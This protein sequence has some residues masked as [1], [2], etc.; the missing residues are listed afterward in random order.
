M[1]LTGRLRRRA[2]EYRHSLSFRFSRRRGTSSGKRSPEL[3]VSL[4]TIPERIRAVGLCLDSILGQ[5]LKPDRIML[6]LSEGNGLSRQDVLTG[7]HS[8]RFRRLIERGVEVRWC[9]DIRSYRKIIPT[10]REHPEALIVTADDDIMYPRHWLRTLFTAYKNEPRYIHCHL[11]HQIRHDESGRPLPYRQWLMGSPGSLGPSLDL[12]P[13]G[14][15]GALYAPGHLHE[16]VLNEEAFLS[17]C[18]T[19]DD[20]WLKAM[21][22]LKGVACKKVSMDTMPLPAIRI[23]RNRALF[24]ENVAGGGNDRQITAVMN[25]YGVFWEALADG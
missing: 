4:T 1:T 2:L 23:P 6:W 21:S 3:I 12:F 11:A 25:R 9:R 20:V 8:G 24:E 14:V 10:M 16:E 15:A 18:P 5:S 7:V 13:T 19:A 17:L 22:L